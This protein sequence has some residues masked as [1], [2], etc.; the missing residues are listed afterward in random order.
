MKIF[1][2]CGGFGTRLDNEGR[3]K[4]KPMVKI[5]N[6]PVLMHLIE[7]FVLQG[8]TNFVLCLG[9][10]YNSIVKFFIKKK[11]VKILSKKKKNHKII[12]KSQKIKFTADL[13]YTGLNSGTGGRILK[14]YKYLKLDEDFLVT[15][16]DGLS[17]VDIKKLINFH[18]KKKSYATLTAVKPKERYGLLKFD[19]NSSRITDFNESKK[20]SSSYVNGGFCVLSKDIIKKIK[21]N[22]VF[23]ELGPL[24]NLIKS[25]KIYAYRHS[26]FWKSLD[27]LKDKNDFNKIIKHGKKPWLK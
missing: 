25:K 27:T 20:H 10:K 4:A 1:I 5:G 17:N 11:N 8:Y 3:L 26:G 6:K 22:K 12:F 15:Y 13:V 19:K 21:N 23:F 16:G 14:A 7:T 24:K 9:Y 18:N 2:L